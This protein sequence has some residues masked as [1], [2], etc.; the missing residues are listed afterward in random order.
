MRL[1]ASAHEAAALLVALAAL[2]TGWSAAAN[3]FTWDDRSAVLSNADA[4]GG[5]LAAVFR[6]DFWGTPLRSRR[7][8]KS[9]RP[10]TVLSFRL[11]FLLAGGHSARL[12][13]AT[14]ALVHAVC[15]LLVWRV[16][17]E[18][19]RRHARGQKLEDNPQD[20]APPS[21]SRADNRESYRDVVVGPLVAGLLFAVHPV[22]CDAVA[23]IVGRADLL[24]TALSLAAFLAYVRGATRAGTRWGQVAMALLLTIAAGLCKELGF[25]N[26]ALLVAYDLLRLQQYQKV[27]TRVRAMKRRV[28]TTVIVGMLAAMIR[29]WIN[30]EHRQMEWNIL[31]N[32][33]VVQESRLT[34]VLSYAHVHAWYLWKLVWPRWLC[35]DYGYNT[36]S[37]IESVLD[38][39]N[40]YTLLAYAT[41]LVGL[42][43]AV[44]QLCG[45]SKTPPSSFLMMSI[46]FGVVPFMPASN[47]IFPVGTVVAERLLYF[48]SVGFCLLVGYIFNHALSIGSK[49]SSLAVKC[50]PV[51]CASIFDFK[52]MAPKLLRIARPLI[53]FCGVLLL[54]VGSY[55][56]YLR[57]VDWVSEEMLFKA[58]VKVVPTN[59]KVLSNE[60]KNLLN[61]DPEKALEYLRVAIGMLPKHIEGHTNAGLAYVTLAAR[62]NFDDD[63]FLN[64]IRHLYKSTM[65]APGHFQ[66]SGF[67][68]G[69]IYMHWINSRL[70]SGDPSLHDFLGSP[71]I[72]RATEFLDRAIDQSSIYPTHFYNRGKLAYEIGDFDTAISYFRS[73]EV[74]NSVVRDRQVDPELLVEASSIYNMLGLCYKKKGDI[75]Q[76]LDMLRKGIAL[77][78]METD[79]HV[80]AAL[81]LK[82]EGRYEEADAQLKAALIAATEPAHIA[83]LREIATSLMTADMPEVVE[84]FLNRAS[85]LEREY[86]V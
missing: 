28:A 15:A 69:E 74:A 77:Y 12:Y 20:A 35:F 56:S 14:N 73:T 24:C 41:V 17:L 38:P 59:V 22:H 39:R 30:G 33:V 57:N 60:A 27:A 5:A 72:T 75:E 47:I 36:I 29:V 19:F 26:F 34:R 21:D 53:L 11:D 7:S 1:D 64:G 70:Q 50:E 61:S 71:S 44:L 78:P 48:P 25:T 66:S 62:N 82:S 37:V 80:N 63:L 4:Q 13:H 2:L 8:H 52:N 42:R 67:L 18:L 79:L 65:L 32:N 58:A 43:S 68:G 3:G 16:A 31:A 49:Y 84:A 9:F 46:A 86:E 51:H 10:L 76:S 54:A 23:S 55:R 81:I 6:D 83:K 45:S 40:V 85:A